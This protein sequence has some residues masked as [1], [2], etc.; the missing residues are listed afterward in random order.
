MVS[1]AFL[2]RKRKTASQPWQAIAQR[3]CSIGILRRRG[4]NEKNRFRYCDTTFC[5]HNFSLF[6]RNGATRYRNWDCRVDFFNYR[7]YRKQVVGGVFMYG[8][9]V[10]NFIIPF[11]MVFVGYILK[12]HPVK[13][14]TSGNGYNTPTSRKS[15]KHWDYAQ[16]I[17]PNIFIGTGKT[18]GLVEIV[19]CISLLLLNISA[20]STVFAGVVVGII[21]LILGF[22]KTETGITSKFANK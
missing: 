3:F 2:F 9:L 21:F 15:Q 10:L 17:A 14:M 4:F 22:Y 11:V 20:Q 8:L 19:L 7:I 13:D 18:L 16:S 12:K 1:T 5:Y 6:I